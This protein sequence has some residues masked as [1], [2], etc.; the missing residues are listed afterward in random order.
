MTNKHDEKILLLDIE[1]KPATAYVWR[2]WDENISPDQLID[3]GGMLCFCAKWSGS[4]D[5]LFFSEWEDGR[6]GMAQAALD[7]LNEADAVVTYNGDRYD[8]PKILGE[9]LLAGLTPPPPV[10]SIDVLKT[11]KKMGFVMNRLAYIGPLLSV[12]GKVK[13]EG[14]NLW[15][16]VMN[17]KETAKAKMRRYCIQDVRLLEKLYQRVRPFIKNHPHMGATKKECGA[18]G[19][20]HVQS[21][22]YRRTKHYR[23]QRV[24]CQSCG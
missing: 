17:G 12:G 18:C 11:V 9:I 19:S 8:L 15:K 6:E 10:T 21:R 5:F 7:L 13:H 2:M 16:D 22:G 3:H 23:I 24:Q 20:N 14:F 4:K 1:W